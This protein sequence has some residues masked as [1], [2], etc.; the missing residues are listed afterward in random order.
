[1]PLSDSR[2]FAGLFAKNVQDARVAFSP[3]VEDVT[4]YVAM[5]HVVQVDDDKVAREGAGNLGLRNAMSAG[6]RQHETA[7]ENRGAQR[8]PLAPGHEGML[9][10]SSGSV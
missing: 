8:R 3:G 7:D 6:S 4:E 10:A 9:G 2:R 1:M 5:L